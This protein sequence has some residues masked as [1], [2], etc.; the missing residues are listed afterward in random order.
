M[1]AAF[2]ILLAMFCFD[3]SARAQS[4]VGVRV[5][6]GLTD[7]AEVKWDASATA[8]SGHIGSIEPWRFEG[9]DAP[10][11]QYRSRS[12]RSESIKHPQQ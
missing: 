7:R 9:S 6:L 4:A 1:K 12:E 10:Q 8:R 5:I 2:A 11:S 3:S